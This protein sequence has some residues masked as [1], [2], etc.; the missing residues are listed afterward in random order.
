VF[1]FETFNSD[2]S[3]RKVISGLDDKVMANQFIARRFDAMIVLDSEA[4]E[5]AMK[6]INFTRLLLRELSVCP[7]IGNYYGMSKKSLRIGEYKRLNTALL[8][9][10][11]SGWVKQI[12]RKYN[13]PPPV[14]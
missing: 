10:L 14:E 1:Y 5:K 12:Y 9:L 8:D 3:I 13:V 4:I 6:D 11:K 7:K 2:T